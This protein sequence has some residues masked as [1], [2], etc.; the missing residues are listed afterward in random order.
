MSL[1]TLDGRRK[2][3]G[4][5]S[6]MPS[7]S[8]GG[9]PAKL[10]SLHRVP[11]FNRGMALEPKTTEKIASSGR[12]FTIRI[13]RADVSKPLEQIPVGSRGILRIGLNWIAGFLSFALMGF[14]LLTAIDI[15]FR[16]NSALSTFYAVLPLLS[17]PVFLMGFLIRKMSVVQAVLAVS[18]LTICVALNWRTCSA[19]GYCPGM[20]ST[21]LLTLET[22]AVLAFLG[23]AAASLSATMLA[24]RKP[25][26]RAP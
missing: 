5:N 12:T 18:F 16:L 26:S 21:I 24:E 2:N 22:K 25:A 19:L 1:A 11:G 4:P 9:E 14:G 17:F 7:A 3:C 15:D 8:V 23:A 10:F 13:G 6:S 20:F